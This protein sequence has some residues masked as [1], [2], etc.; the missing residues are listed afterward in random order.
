[1]WRTGP[2]PKGLQGYLNFQGSDGEDLALSDTNPTI[3]QMSHT[4]TT[5]M[6]ITDLPFTV[7]LKELVSLAIGNRKAFCP[8]CQSA[9]KAISQPS[10][11]GASSIATPVMTAVTSTSLPQTAS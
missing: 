9:L 7:I 5:S 2:L 4:L 6:L 11:S 10:K 3:S 8:K 1:M